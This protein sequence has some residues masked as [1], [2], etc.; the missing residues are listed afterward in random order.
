MIKGNKERE[1]I[2]LVGPT[3]IGKTKIAIEIS[4]LLNT[5]IVSAD[6]IQ[7][8]IGM[9]IGTSKP[10][11]NQRKEI[12]HHMIDICLPDHIMTV[13]EFQKLARK[14]IDD[15]SNKGKT[16]FLVGGSGLYIRAVIDDL[17]FA[18]NIFNEEQRYKIRKRVESEGLKSLFKELIKIDQEYA[19]KI[20]PTDERRII[21]ALEV[22]YISGKKF[23][24]FQKEWNKRKSIYNLTMIGLN[25]N[26][27]ELYSDIEKRVDD[28]ISYGL[29]EEVKGLIE[30]GYRDSLSLKQA[31]GYKEVLDFYN[32]EL[33]REETINLI[34]K[35]TRN[36]AK[37]QLTWL[38]ADPRIN[39]IFI[40]K[41]EKFD[42][43]IKK[44]IKIIS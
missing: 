35:N 37:R 29:F 10:T 13:A 23:S 28:M 19:K 44:I 14:C 24:S 25:K 7:V 31:I 26:R 9:D 21:R 2:A 43:I 40:K 36:F 32:G 39:W 20:S 22:Y 4:K 12:V 42:N 1:L 16:P 5:E 18:N 41:S 8:Y 34:K 6:S 27:N 15:I 17:H 30:K 38:K 11:I 3:C 33:S